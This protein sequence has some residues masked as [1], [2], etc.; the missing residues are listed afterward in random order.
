MRRL[1]IALAAVIASA[2][3]MRADDTKTDHIGSF[4]V[5]TTKDPFGDRDTVVAMTI[6]G[7]GAF[8]MRCIEGALSIAISSATMTFETG[9]TFGIKIRADNKDIFEEEGTALSPVIIEVS[10]EADKIIEQVSGAKTVAVR[11]AGSTVLTE[12]IPLQQSD[13]A[14]AVVKKACT[15]Q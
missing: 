15:K 8:A 11:I 3:P 9:D 1:F 5:S 14:A 6:G 7:G 10:E 4:M 13:K 12:T 2:M